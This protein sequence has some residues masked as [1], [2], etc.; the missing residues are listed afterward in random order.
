MALS[1]GMLQL[2]LQVKTC[3]SCDY[4]YRLVTAVAPSGKLVIAVAVSNK[5]FI[6]VATSDKPLTAVAPSDKLVIY[7]A[8]VTNDQK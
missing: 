6:A 3:Y 4:K 8:V 1:T 7:V 5:L 2:W